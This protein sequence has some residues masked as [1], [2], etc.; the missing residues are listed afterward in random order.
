MKGWIVRSLVSLNYLLLTVFSVLYDEMSFEVLLVPLDSKMISLLCHLKFIFRNE[1]K[2]SPAFK[3]SLFFFK[4]CDEGGGP[5]HSH[6]RTD[7]Q[8]SW[9]RPPGG[10]C[11]DSS[12]VCA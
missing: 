7:R 6:D 11:E 10:I 12:W 9:H 8:S 2:E 1:N 3:I 4:A 5:P